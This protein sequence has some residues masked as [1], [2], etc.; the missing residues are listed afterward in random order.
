MSDQKGRGVPA[1]RVTRLLVSLEHVLGRIADGD[2]RVGAYLTGASLSELH[3]SADAV[4]ESM[5]EGVDRME[6]YMV[7]RKLK[8]LLL[9]LG[10]F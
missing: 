2:T 8:C 4:V 6:A 10:V 3:D 7:S 1:E 5:E 9:R